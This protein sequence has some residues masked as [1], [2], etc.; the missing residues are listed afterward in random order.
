MN[1][2]KNLNSYEKF[3]KLTFKERSELSKQYQ[4]EMFSHMMHKEYY[5]L[6]RY[7]KEEGGSFWRWLDE[8]IFK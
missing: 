3:M 4:E 5:A 8:R 7:S 2:T 1:N 6:S